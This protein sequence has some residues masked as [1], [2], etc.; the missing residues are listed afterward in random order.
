MKTEEIKLS[1][2]YVLSFSASPYRDKYEIELR[3]RAFYPA[4][5]IRNFME[6]LMH[7]SGKELTFKKLVDGTF[8][9]EW[10]TEE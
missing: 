7:H 10:E 8:E 9:M 3:I 6:I 5:D 2:S 4:A 1:D